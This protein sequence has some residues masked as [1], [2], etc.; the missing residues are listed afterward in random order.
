M[1]ELAQVMPPL[2][3][4]LIEIATA[5]YTADR[6]QARDH[7]D[8]CQIAWCR[9]LRLHLP[10]R[11]VD[12]WQS[13]AGHVGE[14]LRWLTDDEWELVFHPLGASHTPLRGA[15]EYLFSEVPDRARVVLFS[16]GLDS[17]AGL[18]ADLAAAPDAA[19]LAVRVVTSNRMQGIQESVLRALGHR[20]RDCRL[21]LNLAAGTSRESTQRTRGFLFLAAGIATALT[22]GK[23]T[24]RVYENGIGAI[25]L[26]LVPAQRGS[27]A[28]RAVHPRTLQMLE[29]LTTSLTGARFRIELPHLWHTKTEM[30]RHVPHWAIKACI[31]SVTCDIGFATHVPGRPACGQCT[32]CILRRQSVLASGQPVLDTAQHYDSDLSS[33]RDRVPITATL[34]QLH[35]LGQALRAADPWTALVEEFPQVLDVPAVGE[36]TGRAAVLRLYGQYCTEWRAAAREFGFNLHKW[37]LEGAAAA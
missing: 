32:S 28:T 17:T 19:V 27:Q 4:D 13:H 34:W 29:R 35:R 25:N 9:R 24:L 12:V 30:L 11:C 21:P 36:E 10:V 26:P 22:A 15:Q 1:D 8:P 7:G 2:A 5:A 23:Q 6:R 31:R 37:G 20:V 3:A 14:V 33:A 18:A 16:G